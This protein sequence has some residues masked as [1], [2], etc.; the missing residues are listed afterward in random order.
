MINPES[1][2]NS[3]RVNSYIRNDRASDI[4]NSDKTKLSASAPLLSDIASTSVSANEA[5][6]TIVPEWK[7]IENALNR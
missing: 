2:C 4:I 3:C 7:N 1:L 6:K 5:T